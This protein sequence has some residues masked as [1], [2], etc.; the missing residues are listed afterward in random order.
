MSMTSKKKVYGYNTI[1]REECILSRNIADEPFIVGEEE[2][3]VQGC[4]YLWSMNLR[5]S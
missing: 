1:V 5:S 3:R 2:T 4:F